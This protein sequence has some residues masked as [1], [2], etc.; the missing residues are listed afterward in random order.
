MTTFNTGN[1]LGS[2]DVYDRYDNSE[3]LDNFSNG[4]LDSYTDR[5]GVPR[6]SLQGIRNAISYQVLGPYAAG[7]N[8]TSY[9]QVFS[10]L[11]EFY[12][13]GP[14]ITLPYTT[15]GVGAGEIVNFRSVGDAILRSDL[16]ASAPGKGATLVGTK[17]PGSTLA[18]SQLDKN[19]ERYYLADFVGVDLTGATDSTAAVQAAIDYCAANGI[20]L[21]TGRG[22]VMVSSVL[23]KSNLTL[24]GAGIGRFTFKRNPAAPTGYPIDITNVN[25][26]SLSHFSVDGNKSSAV[27]GGNNIL[28]AGS[29][30]N[31]CLDS[32]ESKNSK[33][34]SGFGSGILAIGAPSGTQAG[35]SY[36]KNCTVT[37]NDGTGITVQRVSGLTITDNYIYMNSG[38]G[39][40]VIN[41]VFPPV[42]DV[43]ND[44]EISRNRCNYNLVGIRGLGYYRG[45]SSS[46]PIYGTEIPQS[47]HVNIIGN[48]C[49]FNAEYGIAWQTANAII[50]G[51]HI[52]R[53]GNSM[54]NGGVLLNGWRCQ[55]IANN[56][57]DNYY[58]GIDAG[59]AINCTIADNMFVRT[60]ATAGLGST[61]INMGAAQSLIVHGNQIDQTGVAG[62]CTA[63]GA[64]RWDGDGVT[65]FPTITQ[66]LDIIDN[67]IQSNGNAASIGIYLMQGPSNIKLQGNRV[68]GAV[69]GKDYIIE[70]D[71]VIQSNNFSSLWPATTGIPA[72]VATAAT[73][74]VIPDVAEMV[75]VS[76]GT[77]I[78]RLHTSSADIFY[79]KV[80]KVNMTAAGTGYTSPPAVNFS[81]GGGSG[82]VGTALLGSDGTVVG[83]R[84]T[85]AGTGY[86]SN[87]SVSLT[88]GGGSGATCTAI[89]GCEN[90]ATRKITLLFQNPVTITDGGNLALAGNMVATSGSTL[91]LIGYVGGGWQETSRA[92]V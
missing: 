15:T 75:L 73:N 79:Q 70:A 3:N 24:R 41:F 89:A 67:L 38:V 33:S 90:F 53:N 31:Y 34:V 63:I 27:N 21:H 84:V 52:N 20:D 7:L 76:G 50:M 71:G 62:A 72:A 25:N 37:D 43:S 87:P 68:R 74:T 10:Y 59:G 6:Q 2:T 23:P 78:A 39:I 1:P 22:T 18:R 46:A 86:T 30:S 4:P 26:V 91:S 49:N 85:S 29:S 45:G 35:I 17:Q 36:I 19:A 61:D 14:A 48:M 57:E 9:G 54:A 81:G 5:F 92:I 83:V 42:A 11:G 44:L 51:N 40:D 80:Y 56:L 60:G 55:F 65:Y 58:Y 12:A 8:F 88:G 66:N 32:I 69:A 13:P 82:A 64:P 28:I 16:A 47:R 77:S